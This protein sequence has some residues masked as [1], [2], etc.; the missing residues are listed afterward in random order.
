M[1][2][3]P[4]RKTT[5]RPNRSSSSC[6]A[7]CRRSFPA[8]RFRFCRPTSQILNFGLPAPI[9]VQVVGNNQAANYAYATELLKRIRTV[10]GIGDARIQQ[11]FN[12]PQINVEVDR[13]LAGVVGLTQRDVANS[14][15]VTLSG[16]QQVHP[17]F[18]LNPENGVSYPLV[19]QMPQYRIDTRSD[20]ANVPVTSTETKEPQY[21]GGLAQITPGPSAGVVSHYNVQPVIDIYGAIQQRDLGA[22]AA[23]VNQILQDT[24]KDVPRGS[25]VVLR[26]QVQTMTSAYSQ[27]YFGLAGAILLIYLVIVVNFSLGSIPSSSSPRFRRRSRANQQ[28]AH[29]LHPTQ[30]LHAVATIRR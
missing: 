15:L 4:S 18:W 10:P 6:A 7:C 11:V 8:R 3:S 19:A 26:G 1:P 2:S 29:G 5:R 28:I 30:W 17:N 14:L 22:V 12:Y 13:T 24:R 23:D 27:L 21:L 25:Y 16:S 9:D 20:L